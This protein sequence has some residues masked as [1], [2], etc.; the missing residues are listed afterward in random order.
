MLDC[1]KKS[2]FEDFSYLHPLKTSAQIIAIARE[3]LHNEANAILVYSKNLNNSFPQAVETLL[4]NTGNV[5]VTGVGKSALIGQKIVATFNSTGTKA[6]FMHATEA[7]H[8]DL[9]MVRTGDVVIF[10]SH[11][12]NTPEI[13][14]LVPYIAQNGNSIIAITGNDT[15][16]LAT[17]CNYLLHTAIEKEACPLNLA[18]TTST[19]LQLAV[20]DALAVAL[21]ECR[22]FTA[23]DFA[24]YHPGGA[25]G[26]KL[27]MRVHDLLTSKSKPFVLAHTPIKEVIFSI[28]SSRMGAT[29]VLQ[30]DSAIGIVTDGDIRRML[31]EHDNLKDIVAQDI[32]S[33]KPKTI[34]NDALAVESLALFKTHNISQLV[35]TNAGQY[36]GLIHIHDL[37]KE[38]VF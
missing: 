32:M 10:I 24:K 19:T 5:V 18:P 28:T 17:N 3:T 21:L 33:K 31:E 15:S 38:G 26:K 20:G 8:G 13:K 22:G 9:G 34:D 2:N 36:A 29:V 12:G 27:F 25:L 6:V 11:S 37:M 1:L 23:Q 14:A 7:I 35:V 16:F 30:N 4:N